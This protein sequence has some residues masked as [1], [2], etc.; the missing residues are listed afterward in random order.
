MKLIEES[1]GTGWDPAT[2]QH[3]A[4]AMAWLERARE[5]RM[6]IPTVTGMVDPR[7]GGIEPD[8]ILVLMWWT[9]HPAI[10]PVVV[11][12]DTPERRTVY[13]EVPGP[14]AE[15]WNDYWSDR[16]TRDADRLDREMNRGERGKKLSAFRLG[17]IAEVV[18]FIEGSLRAYKEQAH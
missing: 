13:W 7:D 12:L 14:D 18:D 3:Q 10:N 8:G 17:T 11:M 6:M 1:T 15:G 16:F 2:M 5:G 4:A 9:R